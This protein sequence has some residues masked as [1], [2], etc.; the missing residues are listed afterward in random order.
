MGGLFFPFFPQYQK[1]N[2]QNTAMNQN[3]NDDSHYSLL[4]G[5]LMTCCNCWN[6]FEIY[7]MHLILESILVHKSENTVNIITASCMSN[8][9]FSLQ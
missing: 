6:F 2:L 9:Y 4:L 1:M 5:L 7:V 8:S 3:S